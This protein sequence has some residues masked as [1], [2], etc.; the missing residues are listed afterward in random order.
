MVVRVSDYGEGHRI[1]DLLTRNEGLQKA[2]APG[3]RSS[4]R[5]FA[6]ILEAG[7]RLSV[8]LEK[9]P[10]RS[11][12]S[13]KEASLSG[14]AQTGI[15]SNLSAMLQAGWMLDLCRSLV[16]DEQPHSDLFDLLTQ[17]LDS[18]DT[19]ALPGWGLVA[20]EMAALSAFGV[21]PR[22]DA[23]CRCERE[24]RSESSRFSP[25]AG[26]LL[27]PVCAP[28]WGPGDLALSRA[29]LRI[30]RTLAEL[31]CGPD[32]LVHAADFPDAPEHIAEARTAL[33]RCTEHVLDRPLKSRA[34]LDRLEQA[35]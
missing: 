16:R 14:G 5:R 21:M 9:T 22:F 7:N 18:L 3:A 33:L 25:G 28:A 12:C 30:L 15:R 34:L 24:P 11:L 23:C 17:G 27:C 29:T 1:V 10:R 26:G 4:K 13:L 35:D 19:G 20:F 32:V 31:G 8:V 6:G 2:F